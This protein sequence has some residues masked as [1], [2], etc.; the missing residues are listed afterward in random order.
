M[1]YIAYLAFLLTAV[2]FI[3]AL[4]NIIFLQRLP[5]TGKS[6]DKTVSVLIPARN[7]E[8]HIENLLNDLLNQKHQKIEI[9]VYNDES[10]D[11]T[12]DI[13]KRYREFDKRIK[14]INGDK[15]PVG[16]LGKNYACYNLS[17]HATGDYFL[18]LDSDVRIGGDIIT[19]SIEYAQKHR[20][21]LFSIFPKQIMKSTGEKITVPIMNY[22][23]L[24]LLP[25]IFVRKSGF[26]SHS[27][28][29]GQFMFFN[30][31]TYKKI[32]PHEKVKSSSFEDIKTARI[33][34]KKKNKI[35]CLTGDNR[36]RCRMYENFSEALSGFSKNIIAFFGNSFVIAI[37]FWLITTFG[38]IAVIFSMPLI[39]FVYFVLIYI[40]VR[41]LVSI[42]AG[43]S[44][45]ENIIYMP[46]QQISMG[47]IIYKAIT[48]KLNNK[49]TWKG[50]NIVS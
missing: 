27:A 30:A 23:L 4:S 17:K 33:F 7:E 29:N 6:S 9:I 11:K 22:I 37:L 20:L 14:L 42:A 34:K 47:R 24:S 32:N 49:L 39:N 26:K 44:I 35:A 1:I 10:T 45:F 38:F 36:I 19:S 43:Q 48:N 12:A 3:V 16:W 15:L 13:V 25:L 50:R 28:A 46:L 40:A 31:H 8:G 2:Q 21:G 5:K 41:I 18:F